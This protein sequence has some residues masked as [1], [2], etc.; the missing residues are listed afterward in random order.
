MRQ[1]LT[2]LIAQFEKLLLMPD[3]FGALAKEWLNILFGETL[4]GIGFLIWWALGEPKNHSLV[5]A[6]LIAMFVA[7]YYA[8]R[9]NYIRLQP[10]FKVERIIAQR[11]D[12]ETP[13]VVKI[14]L[15][16][17]PECLTDA[18]VKACHGRLLLVSQLNGRGE[19]VPTEMNSPLK[20]GWDYYG[21]EPLTIE[22]GIGQRL[23]V[24]FWDSSATAIVPTVH[25][26]PSKWR[27]I[28]GPGPFKFDIRMVAKRCEP[29]DFS[30]TVNLLGRKWDDPEYALIQGRKSGARDP[31]PKY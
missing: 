21:Y 12:T 13:G 8:W 1:F 25:P 31:I 17:L 7:G 11:T 28:I 23:D 5:V 20:L 4:V 10:R 18:P 22:P 16:V 26:L 30:V 15:Q 19:W 14:Y 6:F 27:S 24:C 3:Y 9:A 2:W 29:V